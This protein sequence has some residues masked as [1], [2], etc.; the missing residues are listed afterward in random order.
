MESVHK[1]GE[2]PKAVNGLF[3]DEQKQSGAHQETIADQSSMILS[4]AEMI[5]SQ[6]S[7]IARQT[8]VLNWIHSSRTW[9]IVSKL[10]KIGE[11]ITRWHRFE[12]RI[13]RVLHRLWQPD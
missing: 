5:S 11:A 2:L 1:S 12:D 4:Q 7:V 3:S 8:E 6:A 9:R 13:C 10:R